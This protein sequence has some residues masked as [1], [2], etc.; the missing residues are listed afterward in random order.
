MSHFFTK[1]TLWCWYKL[2]PEPF[3]ILIKCYFCR[4]PLHYVAVNFIQFGFIILLFRMY[5]ISLYILCHISPYP[6]DIPILRNHKHA[7][8]FPL[9]EP[10]RVVFG[11]DMGINIIITGTVNVNVINSSILCNHAG[12][13]AILQQNHHYSV[14]ANHLQIYS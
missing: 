2:C 5:N 11:Q 10:V 12:Q 1:I 4:Y 9:T 6:E 7:F 3:D 14:T 8:P 13:S